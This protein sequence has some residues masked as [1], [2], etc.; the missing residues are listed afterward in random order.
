L[1]LVPDHLGEKPTDTVDLIR[2]DKDGR[3]ELLPMRWGL[4]PGWWKKSAKEVPATHSTGR[5]ARCVRIYP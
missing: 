1:R 2:L 4:I 3:R 5:R